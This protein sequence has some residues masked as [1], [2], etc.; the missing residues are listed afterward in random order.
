[1]AKTIERVEIDPEE[2]KTL[3]EKTFSLSAYALEEGVTLIIGGADIVK[4]KGFAYEML[5]LSLYRPADWDNKKKEPKKDAEP[6]VVYLKSLC[7]EIRDYRNEVV[8]VTGTLNDSVKELLGKSYSDVIAFFD[9]R[10]GRAVTTTLACFKGVN[11]KGDTYE[12][13]RNGFN[14]VK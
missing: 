9:E 1:M 6:H 2:K 12:A 14:W 11:R 3:L 13:R 8:S 7:R 5:V 4:Q 10:K